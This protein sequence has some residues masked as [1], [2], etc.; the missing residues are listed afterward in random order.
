MLGGT[1]LV[2]G[3]FGFDLIDVCVFVALGDPV[4]ADVGDSV[5]L[6]ILRLALFC[7]YSALAGIILDGR[8]E[9]SLRLL[10]GL[11][12]LHDGGSKWVLIGFVGEHTGPLGLVRPHAG[13]IE[14]PLGEGILGGGL[15]SLGGRFL[16]FAVRE[17]SLHQFEYNNACN[18]TN[19]II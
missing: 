19:N 4:L 2:E 12:F 7:Q 8:E 17:G 18:Y 11:I 10:F 3:L 9:V 14:Q 16:H 6:V 1:S 15:E 13:R 5:V